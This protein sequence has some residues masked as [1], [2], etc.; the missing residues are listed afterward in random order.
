[1]TRDE[2]IKD[3]WVEKDCIVGKDW[4]KLGTGL[5]L[6]L[7]KDEAVVYST[8]DYTEPLGVAKTLDELTEF[9]KKVRRQEIELLET[10]V[11]LLKK[12]Y[13]REFNQASKHL[14]YK[15]FAE[16]MLWHLIVKHKNEF[17]GYSVMLEDGPEGTGLKKGDI[18]QYSYMS[19]VPP[20]SSKPLTYKELALE[21]GLFTEHLTSDSHDCKRCEKESA[22][23]AYFKYDTDHERC[24][25]WK[26]REG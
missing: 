8:E 6:I 2:L 25:G 18:G 16:Q 15:P 26:E 14:D 1:M 24:I 13:E 9:R 10:R 22:C 19:S 5:I 3:G 23:T 17:S 7:L 20:Q 11:E 4:F 21:L 12:A